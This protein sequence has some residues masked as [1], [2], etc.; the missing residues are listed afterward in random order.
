MLGECA[1]LIGIYE[2]KGPNGNDLEAIKSYEDIL[3]FNN[4]QYVRLRVEQPDF[5]ARVRELS[6]FIMRFTIIESN[7][8]L[9]SDI[10]P[11]VEREF[12]VTCYPNQS[13][14]WLYDDKVRQAFAMIAHGYPMTKA[15]IFYEKRAAFDWA[16]QANYPVVFKLKGGAGSTNVILVKSYKQA[17]ALIRQMFGG[18][19]YP[20]SFKA[21]GLVRF[22]HFNLYREIHHLG[23]NIYRW[24]KGLDKSPFWRPHKNYAYFQKFLPNNDHDTRITIIGERA[25]AFRRLVREN[26][27]RASGSGKID[28]DTSKIDMRFVE[29]GFVISQKMGFKCMAYDFLENEQGEP[30]ICEISYAFVSSAIY[31]CPGYWDR[32]LNWHGGHFWPEH[33][34]LMDALGLPELKLPP[35]IGGRR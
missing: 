26:D 12:G 8:Q 6:L 32:E 33:L 31:D 4:I 1:L 17:S 23:G 29:L 30:E 14:A 11:I 9:K 5:W 24:S 27:F 22:K 35:A 3:R 20:E 7:L 28:Y 34:H 16:K 15:W 13:M 18:G 19:V 21:L 25:F 10:L 2:T